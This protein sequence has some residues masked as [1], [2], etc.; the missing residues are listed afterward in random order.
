TTRQSRPQVAK[1]ISFTI[2]ATKSLKTISFTIIATKS[3][4]PSALL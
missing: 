3:Q 2:V 4:K 1:T